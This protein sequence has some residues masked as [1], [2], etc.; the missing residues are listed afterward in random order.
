[1]QGK[2]TLSKTDRRKA[3]NRTFVLVKNGTS[4]TDARRIVAGELDL[5]PNTLLNWQNKFN[6]S[7]PIFTRT[8][9]LIQKNGQMR[10]VTHAVSKSGS[11][12]IKGIESMKGQLGVVFTSLVNQD[13]RF[14]NQDAGAISGVANNILGCCKQV[15]LE[16]KHSEKANR[17]KSL[18]K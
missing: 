1:M 16:R 14:T 2:V 7:T 5:S 6:M 9:H 12:V 10:Q 8:S 4:I 13:G 11:A 3:V 17:T 15:L 18:S